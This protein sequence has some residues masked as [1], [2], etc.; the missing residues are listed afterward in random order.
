MADGNWFQ[1]S[2]E[3]EIDDLDGSVRQCDTHGA[4][5][6]CNRQAFQMSYG[7]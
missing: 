1:S 2:Y 7:Q 6:W 3:E 4:A 5:G